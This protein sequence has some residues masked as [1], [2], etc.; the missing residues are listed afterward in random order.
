MKKLLNTAFLIIFFVSVLSCKAGAVVLDKEL[1]KEKIKENIEKQI[2][3]CFQ[4]KGRIEIKA[5]K[6]PYGKIEIDEEN[7]DDLQIE[8]KMNLKYFNPTTIVRINLI[9]NGKIRKS[10]VSQAKIS[11][12][13]KVWTATDYIKRGE[14]LTNVVFG[15]RETTYLNKSIRKENFDIYKY[16]SKKN[17]RPGEAIDTSFIEL[18]PDIVKDGFVFVLFKSDS[19][20]ITIPAIALDKGNIGEYIKVRSKEFK[21]DYKGKIISKSQ[22]LVNI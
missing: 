14:S 16:I 22:I 15:E 20:S 5:V 11:V 2:K 9:V 10:F 12:Y 17:Y 19:I 7:I 21:K 18:A 1:L 3:S 13:D 4:A 8:T 6:L